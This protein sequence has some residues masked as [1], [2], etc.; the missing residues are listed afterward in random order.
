MQ[1][2]T[3]PSLPVIPPQALAG[4]TRVLGPRIWDNAVLGFTRASESS[5][6]AG[7]PFEQHVQQRAAE[8][9]AAI[10]KVRGGLR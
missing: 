1:H 4:I 8:L 3:T 7:V 9:T 5:T 10:A 2:Q 6:P